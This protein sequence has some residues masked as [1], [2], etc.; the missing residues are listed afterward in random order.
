MKIRM[1]SATGFAVNDPTADELGNA[2]GPTN[3]SAAGSPAVVTAAALA[4]PATAPSSR[5]TPANATHANGP[6]TGESPL[7]SP[8]HASRLPL[9]PDTAPAAAA[10]RDATVIAGTAA[11]A[12]TTRS[13]AGSVTSDDDGAGPAPFGVPEAIALDGTASEGPETSPSTPPD[14]GPAPDATTAGTTA[15][16]V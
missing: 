13:A 3:D 12:A 8:S 15:E 6:A 1:K 10:G 11:A 16:P 14:P 9:K 4:V 7:P 2:A 5:R